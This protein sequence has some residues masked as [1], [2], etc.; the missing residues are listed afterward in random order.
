MKDVELKETKALPASDGTVVTTAI[1]LMNSS[2]GYFLGDID[3]I[4]TA[5]A[6]S[7]SELPDADTATYKLEESADDSSFSDLLTSVIAQVGASGAGAAAAT[8]TIRLPKK[9]KRYVRLSV[10]T[11]GTSGDCSGKSMTLELAM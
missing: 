1:D 10:T 5:P 3:C 7:T 9:V 11:A 4:I 2:R 8:K 6:L